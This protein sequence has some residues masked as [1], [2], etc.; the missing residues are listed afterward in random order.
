MNFLEVKLLVIVLISVAVFFAIGIIVLYVK[1]II[2]DRNQ[3]R[4]HCINYGKDLSLCDGCRYYAFNDANK[5][6][7]HIS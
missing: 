5:K 7:T 3:C 2:D 1:D 4:K 6:T